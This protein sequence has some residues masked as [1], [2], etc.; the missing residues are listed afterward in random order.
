MRKE[1]R[2][3]GREGGRETETDLLF[4]PF[5]HALGASSMCP[6]WRL[7]LQPSYMEMMP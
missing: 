3:G 1:G 6:D 7:N 4:H 5:M 2:S